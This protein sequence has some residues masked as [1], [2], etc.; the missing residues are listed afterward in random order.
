MKYA[1]AVITGLFLCQPLIATASPLPDRGIG[2]MNGLVGA[3]IGVCIAL[4]IALA[5]AGGKSGPPD[6]KAEDETGH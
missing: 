4:F 5:R 6:K 1:I 3:A 2:G